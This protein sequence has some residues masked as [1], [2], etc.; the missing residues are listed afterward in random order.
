MS[1]P[2]KK[3]KINV[4]I[5]PVPKHADEYTSM[6]FERI[7]ELMINT[8][9]KTNRFPADIRLQ[10][11]DIAVFEWVKNGS[12]NM[13]IDDSDVSV[14][15]MEDERWAEF[16]KTWIIADDDKNVAT[17][18]LTVRRTGIEEGTRLGGKANIPYKHFS[19]LDQPIMDD[20]EIVYLRFLIPQPIN[21]DAI[22]EITLYSK[23]RVDINEMDETVLKAFSSIQDYIYV[24]GNPMSILLEDITSPGSVTNVMEDRILI[25]TYNI[26]VRGFIQ[27][28][29][30]FKI[31]KTYRKPKLTYGVY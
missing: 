11:I 17:P 4:D 14:F 15:Y 16:S 6:G 27:K 31:I 13:V 25:G 12:L 9:S 19:Y 7:K 10:D 22:Y 30:E 8:D 18:Y 2:A 5:M 24:H 29:D 21:V 23:Y 26:R 3:S 20:G 28:Q 1:L